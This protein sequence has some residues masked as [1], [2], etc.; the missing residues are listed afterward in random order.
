MDRA[1]VLFASAVVLSVL[2]RVEIGQGFVPT[3][4]GPSLRGNAAGH[5]A[6]QAAQGSASSAWRSGLQTASTLLAVSSCAMAARGTRRGRTQMSA[7]GSP[8]LV[9]MTA[10][11][12]A[13]SK[14]GEAVQVSK[15]VM[16]VN[17]F[18]SD[19]E[20]LVQLS[21]IT[22]EYGITELDKAAA[23]IDKMGTLESSVF[24]KFLKY[25]AKK[26]RLGAVVAICEEYIKNLY[27][28]NGV[29]PVVV[30][31]AEPLSDG[32]KEALKEKMKAKTGAQ[33]VKLICKLNGNLIAGFTLE[34]GYV[35][36]Q[37]LGTPCQGE[38]LSL[39]SILEK[40]AVMQGVTTTV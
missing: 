38:D 17:D 24:P 28:T 37:N 25:L 11:Q 36:P 10:L 22:A 15:D 33:D 40:R 29:V 39:K 4:A 31:S 2:S 7:G 6:G 35:D 26:R 3:T 8:T 1:S 9:Y 5:A 30:T 12:E 18:Y 16:K 21:E 32:Q 20:F 13:A 14:Q 27:E 23:I 34:W 19:E